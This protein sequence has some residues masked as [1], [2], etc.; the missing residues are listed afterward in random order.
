MPRLLLTRTFQK[1]FERLEPGIQSRVRQALLS[2]R[3]DP[4]VGKQLTGDLAGDLSLRVGS[5]R[6]IYAVDGD[7]IWIET[8]GH[9]RDVY[10]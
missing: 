2:I 7:D 9:R 4:F 3:Q 5:Y 1:R 6:I 8:V 10:R